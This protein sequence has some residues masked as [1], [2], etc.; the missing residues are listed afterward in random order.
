MLGKIFGQHARGARAAMSGYRGGGQAMTAVPPPRQTAQSQTGPTGDKWGEFPREE[1]RARL[2]ARLRA[3]EVEAN[4]GDRPGPFADESLTGADVFWLAILMLRELVGVPENEAKKRLLTESS[5][6]PN[7]PPLQLQKANLSDANLMGAHLIGADLSGA[8]LGGAK[9]AGADL[10]GAKLAGAD[11][12]GAKLAGADLTFGDLTKANLRWADLTEANLHGAQLVGT[13][14]YAA[15]L[16]G[17]DLHGAN[18]T[19]ADLSFAN[20]VGTNLR[21]VNLT[22]ANCLKADLARADLYK[23]N[24]TGANLRRTDLREANLEE[25]NLRGTILRAIE[26]VSPADP[27]T[28]EVV[29]PADLRM[30]TL[31]ARTN[32]AGVILGDIEQGFVSVADVAWNSVNLS[33]V[34]WDALCSSY[35]VLGDESRAYTAKGNDGRRKT[36]SEEVLDHQDAARAYRQLSIALQAQGLTE[37]SAQLGYRAQKIGHRVL[38]LQAEFRA[39]ALQ[40]ETQG[41]RVLRLRRRVLEWPRRRRRVWFSWVLDVVAGY[42]YKPGKGL[43]TYA[44]VQAAFIALY[45]AIGAQN[46]LFTG[47]HIPTGSTGSQAILTALLEAGILSVTSFHGRAFLPGSTGNFVNNVPLPTTLMF[48]GAAAVEAVIGLLIEAILVATLIQRF[49]R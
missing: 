36:Q 17:A 3:W 26:A 25:A 37:Q 16:A 4:H 40:D 18:L 27:R 13:R 48:G 46:F 42:G 28:I 31:D 6:R 41:R 32:L 10:G 47:S 20:L 21:K 24:L 8:D 29:P 38:E 9:L 45:L 30:A 22:R 34:T 14:L 35:G 49:F 2:T 12:G 1:R 23:A 19:G 44:R 43:T 33:N 7:I 5:Q 11:L 15:K 39:C